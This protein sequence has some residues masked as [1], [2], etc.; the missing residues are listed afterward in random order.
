MSIMLSVLLRWRQGGDDIVN[1][2]T[3]SEYFFKECERFHLTDDVIEWPCR[4]RVIA[5]NV[6]AQFLG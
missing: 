2:S 4:N 5:L 3:R 1:F 6:L